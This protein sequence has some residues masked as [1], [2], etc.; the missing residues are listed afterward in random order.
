MHRQ[1]ACRPILP[2]SRL[3]ESTTAFDGECKIH[4]H[5]TGGYKRLI[6]QAG[7][8]SPSF[9]IPSPNHLD[10]TKIIPGSR[11]P[12]VE[13]SRACLPGQAQGG[14]RWKRIGRALINLA[15]GLPWK[16]Q[17]SFLITAVKDG[18]YDPELRRIIQE[19]GDS[20]GAPCQF[21]WL[22]TSLIGRCTISLCCPI[23]NRRIFVRLP[24][25]QTAA[26][27]LNR[28]T[29]VQQ[30]V[31]AKLP[32]QRI[33]NDLIPKTRVQCLS[34]GLEC[35]VEEGLIGRAADSV[36]RDRQWFAD[37]V[38]FAGLLSSA[39][40]T[41]DSRSKIN[42]KE[43]LCGLRPQSPRVLAV[44]DPF[45]DRACEVF[46]RSQWPCWPCHGDYWA[47]NLLVDSSGALSGVI[48]WEFAHWSMPAAFDLMRFL[49]RLR[50]ERLDLNYDRFAFSRAELRVFLTSKEQLLVEEFWKS[51][52][53]PVGEETWFALQTTDW[54]YRLSLQK[55]YHRSRFATQA[56]WLAHYWPA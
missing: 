35:Y 8:C 48:D 38:Q 20:I 34:G 24:L 32:G 19:V 15:G 28:A 27:L 39:S 16:L 6:H 2:R 53:L 10:I 7:L 1:T 56:Q 11:L 3:N 30:W 23:Y 26:Q 51:S 4:L 31:K 5:G 54:L 46:L 9:F 50:L 22:R 17:D 44:L 41:V 42:L 52:R 12:W 25:S 40:E 29:S 45:L 14:P 36:E 13:A 55:E 37:A 21:Q 43:I 47:E 18:D 33:G 49:I